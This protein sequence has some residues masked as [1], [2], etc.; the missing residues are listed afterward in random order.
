[1]AVISARLWAT[2]IDVSDLLAIRSVFAHRKA[3]K[4]CSG[5]LSKYDSLSCTGV[6]SARL[7]KEGACKRS[8]GRAM[9][10]LTAIAFVA[11]FLPEASAGDFDP[12]ARGTR[13][14]RRGHN[15]NIPA[16]D[17]GVASTPGTKQPVCLSFW[18]RLPAEDPSDEDVQWLRSW[19]IGTIKSAKYDRE[20]AMFLPHLR[21]A[22]L[23]MRYVR[24]QRRMV[25]RHEVCNYV[26]D[27][28]LDYSCECSMALCE[29]R[30]GWAHGSS[31]NP[32]PSW[33]LPEPPQRDFGG[34]RARAWEF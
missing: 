33:C 15:S 34:N 10:I 26:A 12:P 6:G 25:S 29:T 17:F 30:G 3:V 31:R 2:I 27:G 28:H 1:M 9:L 8:R 22:M 20:S 11:A 18:N 23:V 32:V 16:I 13:H 19:V 5:S 14:R 24:Q 21:R 7:R 4:C